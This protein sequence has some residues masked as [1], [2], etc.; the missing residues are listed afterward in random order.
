MEKKLESLEEVAMS[1]EMGSVCYKMT[2]KYA[3]RFWGRWS[4]CKRKRSEWALLIL[5]WD[6]IESWRAKATL[7]SFCFPRGKFT[8]LKLESVL[9]L[10]LNTRS[11]CLIISMLFVTFLQ[12]WCFIYLAEQGCRFQRLLLLPGEHTKAE[13]P[14]VNRRSFE[15]MIGLVLHESCSR[16]KRLVFMHDFTL[17]ILTNLLIIFTEMRCS[18]LWCLW[19]FHCCS[20][21]GLVFAWWPTQCGSGLSGSWKLFVSFSG[22]YQALFNTAEG[23][24]WKE[25]TNNELSVTSHFPSWTRTFIAQSC[26]LLGATLDVYEPTET[27]VVPLGNIDLPLM[28]LV[29]F[30]WVG[31]FLCNM[32]YLL[33]CAALPEVCSFCSF[34]WKLFSWQGCVYICCMKWRWSWAEMLWHSAWQPCLFPLPRLSAFLTCQQW[35]RPSYIL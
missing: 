14:V 7:K 4:Y 29:L 6:R 15:N 27:A 32:L 3:H 28:G 26:D 16:R 12:C 9:P 24:G 2:P 18:Q 10:C 35:Q 22:S 17:V 23:R 13:Q 25:Q 5:L 8:A 1:G 33:K 19:W 30:E 21:T 11:F 20:E 34:T 31:R